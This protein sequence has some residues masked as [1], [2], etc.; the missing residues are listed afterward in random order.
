MI[1]LKDENSFKYYTN[2]MIKHNE[3]KNVAL[4]W[5]WPKYKKNHFNNSW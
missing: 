5:T 1:G 4:I 3:K 2:D